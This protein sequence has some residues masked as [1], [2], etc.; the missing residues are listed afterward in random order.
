MQ[1]TKNITNELFRY[2]FYARKCSQ[3]IDYFYQDKYLLVV[4]P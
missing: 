3:Y 2:N 4:K 1:F